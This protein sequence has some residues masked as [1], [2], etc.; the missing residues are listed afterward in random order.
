MAHGAVGS[1]VLSRMGCRKT[2]GMG[3]VDGGERV[4]DPTPW[5]PGCWAPL[6]R[7]PHPIPFHPI[8]SHP[9]LSQPVPLASERAARAPLFMAGCKQTPNERKLMT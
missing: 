7:Q 5:S 2:W 8:L 6:H 9:I 3:K 4:L 1:A